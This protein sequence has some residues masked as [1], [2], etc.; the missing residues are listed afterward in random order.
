MSAKE[1]DLPP[2]LVPLKT[3]F[4]QCFL[5]KSVVSA[6]LE[7]DSSLRWQDG[8]NMAQNCKNCK[9]TKQCCLLF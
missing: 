6:R 1:A 2:S 3:L 9:Q 5:I 8:F 7:H 4:L